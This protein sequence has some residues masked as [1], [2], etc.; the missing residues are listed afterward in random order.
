M[1]RRH[2]LPETSIGALGWL[3]GLGD[4]PEVGSS[5]TC[6]SP[7]GDDLRRVMSMTGDREQVPK[8]AEGSPWI[9]W[10]D[11][12]PP[13]SAGRL[14]LPEMLVSSASSTGASPLMRSRPVSGD[15]RKSDVVAE[16]RSSAQL[17]PPP[18]PSS[19][20]LGRCADRVAPPPTTGW[21]AKKGRPSAHP[22]TAHWIAI[23]DCSTSAPVGLDNPAGILGFARRYYRTNPLSPTSNIGP[24]F[25]LGSLP[26]MS[27]H[28]RSADAQRLTWFGGYGRTGVLT[29]S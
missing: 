5:A 23:Q 6:S 12:E 17:P 4:E 8:R 11:E 18:S 22:E 27:E 16:V 20:G 28:E 1:R 3:A 25:S 7:S 19:A 21:S 10:S 9:P 24:R 2:D 13:L 26:M 15:A 29:I 14:T